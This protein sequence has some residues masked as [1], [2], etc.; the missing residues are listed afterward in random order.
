[1]GASCSAKDCPLNRDLSLELYQDCGFWPDKA[2]LHWAPG[3][4]SFSSDFRDFHQLQ[5]TGWA[6]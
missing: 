6:A 2:D 4:R 1:M 3:G 5:V